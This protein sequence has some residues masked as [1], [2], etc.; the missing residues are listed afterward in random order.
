MRRA[1]DFELPCW[2]DDQVSFIHE[3]GSSPKR[4]LQQDILYQHPFP[5]KQEL[6]NHYSLP[7]DP[8]LQLPQLESP[9]LPHSGSSNTSDVG[10]GFD[11]NQGANPQM[12]SYEHPQRS[13]MSLGFDNNANQAVDQV[14]DWRV[15]DKFVASQLRQEDGPK[16][17]IFTEAAGF[18]LP[19]MNMLLQ[20]ND[21]DV[22]AC[23]LPGTSSC[24][25][26]LWK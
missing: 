12:A 23:S 15:L 20:A 5:C 14:T 21:Q 1:S 2:Y 11:I 24:Q 13:H 3:I 18:Q 9:T 22:E 10:F 4:I 19:D 26:E 6:E 8:F 17:T 16:G 25:E 7:G